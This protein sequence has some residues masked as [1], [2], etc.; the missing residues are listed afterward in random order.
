LVI[1]DHSSIRTLASEFLRDEGYTVLPVPD[2]GAGLAVVQERGVDLI[3][4]DHSTGHVQD[5]EFIRSVRH[6]TSRTLPIVLWTAWPKPDDQA[7]AIGAD[8][9]LEKPISMEALLARV[10]QEIGAP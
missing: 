10:R 7:L 2:V 3:L 1:D 6:Q 5:D 8:G 9:G 4:L